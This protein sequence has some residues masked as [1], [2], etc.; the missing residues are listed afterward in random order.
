MQEREEAGREDPQHLRQPEDGAEEGRE[1]G[2]HGGEEGEGGVED[3]DD[4]EERAVCRHTQGPEG[5]ISG[6]ADG[7]AQFEPLCRYRGRT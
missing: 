7:G 3:A 2:G 4:E 6:E 5:W 1:P